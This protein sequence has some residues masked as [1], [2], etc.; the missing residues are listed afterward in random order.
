MY[1]HIYPA[2]DNCV[3]ILRTQGLP[4]IDYSFLFKAIVPLARRWS[5]TLDLINWDDR[6]DPMNHHPYFPKRVTVMWDTTCFRVQT[7]DDRTFGQHV[8]NG[9]YD[10]AC[11]LVMVGITF[12]GHLVFASKLSKSTAYD[13]RIYHDSRHLHP[14]FDLEQNIGDGHFSTTPQFF[15]PAARTNGRALTPTEIT[16]NEWIQLVR[17][18]IEHLNN[19]FK[20]HR[21]FKG[22]PFRGKAESLKLF[23]NISLHGAAVEIRARSRRDGPRYPGYGPWTH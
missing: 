1:I 12:T 3:D 7:P 21:M 8:V 20:N 18:R 9:H 11:Y 14:Q 23:V 17:A 13:S 4:K 15:V 5:V 19:V 10:F 16:W 2:K 22:E 6:L